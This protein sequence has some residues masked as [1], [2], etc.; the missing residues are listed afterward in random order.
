MQIISKI[1]FFVLAFAAMQVCAQDEIEVINIMNPALQAYMADSTYY[2]DSDY[3]NSVVKNYVG[4]EKY[5]TG[6]DRPQGKVVNWTLTS[7]SQDVAE[8]RITLS[9]SKNYG[10]AIT[11]SPSFGK[12]DTYT[13][14]NLFPDRTYYYKVDE[15]KKDSTVTQLGAGV[16]RTEGQVRMMYVDGAHN[17]RDIGGWPTS[18]G[19]PIKYGILYRSGNLDRVTKE[20]IHDFVEN[21]GVRAELDLRGESKLHSSALGAD[22]D[23]I[24]II[25]DSYVGAVASGKYRQAY[26]EDFK[27]IVARMREG[28]SVDWHCAVGCDRCGTLTYL[29]EGLLGVSEI[30]LA[31]DYELSSFRGHKRYRSHAGFRKLTPYMRS[32][33][34]P[35]DK[36]DYDLAECFY[37]YWIASGVSAEDI[38]YMRKVML[39]VDGDTNLDGEFHPAGWSEADDDSKDSDD[40]PYPKTDSRTAPLQ[41]TSG[42]VPY[43]KR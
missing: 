3:S 33:W 31:R 1:L 5:G 23:F 24:R 34:A 32:K 37:N 39:G 29:I 42:E 13:I 40:V 35:K 18:F 12:K 6:L 7:P 14:R 28:K 15:I 10:N 27:W 41:N 19:V 36:E 22:V 20:G 43:P 2:R 17:V 4:R 38:D 26:V 11:Y 9:E 21:M 25:N 16:F 8:V 30:D